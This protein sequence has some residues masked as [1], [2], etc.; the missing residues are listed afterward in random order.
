MILVIKGGRILT[1]D[2]SISSGMSPAGVA[3]E[4]SRFETILRTKSSGAGGN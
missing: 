2:F 3:L 4:P 1:V